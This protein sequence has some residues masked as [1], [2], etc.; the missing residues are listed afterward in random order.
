MR[1]ILLLFALNFPR[2]TLAGSVASDSTAA[3]QQ[4]EAAWSAQLE[5]HSSS[6]DTLR[7][8]VRIL[9][10]MKDDLNH[11]AD[12]ESE[13]FEKNQCWCKTEM[14]EKKQAILAADAQEMGLGTDVE[15]ALAAMEKLKAMTKQEQ[16]DLTEAQEALEEATK[17]F[18]DKMNDMKK[19]EGDTAEVEQSL[20]NAI[21]VIKTKS[22][23]SLLQT[24]SSLLS[25]MRVLLRD[26]A[27]KN[28]LLLASRP[29]LRKTS[30]LQL[31][32][33]DAMDES[34]L[35]ALDVDGGEVSDTLPLHFAE[36]L[37]ARSARASRAPRGKT[38]LQA[39][40]AEDENSGGV[41]KALAVLTVMHGNFEEDLEQ[42]RSQIERETK[43]FEKLK[44][45]KDAEISAIKK[46][47]SDAKDE[48][49]KHQKGGMLGQKE[50]AELR[51][52]RAKDKAMLI[53]LDR[54]CSRLAP[55]WEKRQQLRGEE[56]TALTEA[57]KIL[58][59]DDSEATGGEKEETSEEE[60]PSFLQLSE[61]D[62][63]DSA[64]EALEDSKAETESSESESS[65]RLPKDDPFTP[66]YISMDNM[67]RELKK[68]EAVERKFKEMCQNEFHE[69]EMEEQ[70]KRAE[71]ETKETKRE[72]LKTLKARVEK[73]LEKL[74]KT[75]NKT[76]QEMIDAGHAREQENKE[77][78]T[79]VADQRA[80]QAVVEKAVEKLKAF[81]DEKGTLVQLKLT[82]KN[83]DAARPPEEFGKMKTHQAGNA[84]IE[85]MEHILSKAKNLE[86]KALEEETEAQKDYEKFVADAT[87]ELK[88]N[89]K[90][91]QLK[92]EAIMDH[93][94]DVLEEQK[95]IASVKEDI[96]SLEEEKVDIHLQC[97]VALRDFAKSQEARRQEIEGIL[98]AK[99]LLRGR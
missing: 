1:T 71:Q 51:M 38:F 5:E 22:G 52:R 35:A 15:A 32:G 56:L 75:D 62:E 72:R 13:M 78:Q 97:D 76:Q 23:R 81:Y 45:A 87:D 82:G 49:L 2:S 64:S 20:R 50:L 96:K 98:E 70:K 39:G 41:G 21:L 53:E 4:L 17:V 9:E 29:A 95:D 63:A 42:I 43:A 57:E 99:A 88:T 19:E 48:L 54:T 8:V 60:A 61:A 86:E 6:D 69:N 40:E 85:L 31:A 66:I 24:D 11:E 83:S 14:G 18:D 12:K 28:E 10:A 26:L 89:M 67:V 7:K 44:R 68:E 58:S 79:V 3:E 46:K 33:G 84:V 94:E 65:S 77:F 91:R 34:L 59:Q 27:M 80:V 25:G 93:A 36:S 37:V 74:Q 73:D 92:K 55:E 30:L 90:A 47:I 16:E